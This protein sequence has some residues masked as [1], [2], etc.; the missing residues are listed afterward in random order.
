MKLG[1][2]Y[3]LL[4]ALA[5]CGHV[6]RVGH[7]LEVGDPVLDVAFVWIVSSHNELVQ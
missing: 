2:L 3:L 1:S 4:L 5:L 6:A 7:L